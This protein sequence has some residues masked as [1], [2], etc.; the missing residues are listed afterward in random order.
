MPFFSEKLG[1]AQNMRILLDISPH[2]LLY[3]RKTK[4][5]HR[6]SLLCNNPDITKE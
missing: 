5:L 6:M 3:W 4:L 1:C 2:C